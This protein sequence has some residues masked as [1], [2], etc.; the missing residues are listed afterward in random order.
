MDPLH[1]RN[2]IEVAYRATSIT[3]P[4]TPAMLCV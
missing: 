1:G 2:M 4:E 3:A